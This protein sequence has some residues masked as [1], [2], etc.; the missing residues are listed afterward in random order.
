M[1][2][3]VLGLGAIAMDIVLRCEDLPRE[4]GFSFIHEEKLMPGGSGANV[5]VTLANMGASCAILA[6]VGDDPYG[7]ILRKDL[8]ES[9]ISTHYLLTKKGGTTL[10]TFITVAHNGAKA[11]YVNLG[12]SFLSLSEEEINPK[13]LQGVKVFYTDMIVGGPA[14]KLTKLCREKGIPIFFNLECT[15]SFM[16]LCGVHRKDLEEMI[17][18]CSLFCTSKEGLSE[19]CAG[20]DE[21]EAG[22][23][24][25]KK[26][27]PEIGV[28]VT[29]GE[30]GAAWINHE[31]TLL[32]PAFSVK[33]IDTTG[34]GDAFAGGLIY[35]YLLKGWEKKRSIEFASACAALKCT[36]PGP[37]LKAKEAEIKQF[38][39]NHQ[40]LLGLEK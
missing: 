7:N 37:R 38:L 26:F 12:D 23:A 35:A 28:V 33:A 31:E 40:T 9:E 1:K 16:E 29:L 15:P 11:I 6:K 19:F 2:L 4:D 20:K 3:D 34:T 5:L 32:I 25:Y 21:I 18:L 17:S 10:H 36:Q 30:R 22:L 39:E 14:L 24:I 8:F 27:H 13:M